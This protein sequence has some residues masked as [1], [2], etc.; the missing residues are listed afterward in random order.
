M[1]RIP[2]YIIEQA[3][4]TDII[5]YCQSHGIALEQTKS[6]YRLAMDLHCYIKKDEPWKFTWYNLHPDVMG[7]AIDFIRTYYRVMQGRFISFPEAVEMLTGYSKSENHEPKWTQPKIH[8]PEMIE[9]HKITAKS[10]NV[11]AYLCNERGFDY[12]FVCHLLYLGKLCQDENKNCV[13]PICD[14]NNNIVTAELRSTW[15][16]WHQV[17]STQNGYGFTYQVGAIV[18]NLVFTE[19]AIDALSLYKL[20]ENKWKSVLFVAMVGLKSKVVE[21]YRNLHPNAKFFIAV[22]TDDAGD[23]FVADYKDATRLRP[24]KQFKDWN[25]QLVAKMKLLNEQ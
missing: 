19:S 1:S 4:K 7:K 13:F 21:H 11:I 23:N 22:D 24:M 16:D 12:K 17:L 5:A 9:G 25:E 10:P 15:T 20:F 8:I 14:E 18:E 3:A 6:H 2:D